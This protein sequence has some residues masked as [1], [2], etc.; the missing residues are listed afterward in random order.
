MTHDFQPEQLESW[1]CHS[2]RWGKASGGA[3]WG[4]EIQEF[5]FGHVELEITVRYST[6]DFL[7]PKSKL[8]ILKE[9]KFP[10]GPAL[11]VLFIAVSPEP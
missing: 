11:S 6:S 8:V 2:S 5:R 7:L 10:E 1:S 9:G 3:S 4:R